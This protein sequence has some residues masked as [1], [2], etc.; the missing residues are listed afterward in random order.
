[1]PETYD[2]TF[3]DTNTTSAYYAI[4]VNGAQTVDIPFN[5]ADPQGDA[6][7]IANA[8][9]GI[10]VVVNGAVTYPYAGATVTYTPESYTTNPYDFTLTF[11]GAST[12]GARLRLCNP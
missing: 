8:I 12:G 3:Y 10:Q 2:I 9:R 7:N 5:A 11:G 4:V 1:M 6:N